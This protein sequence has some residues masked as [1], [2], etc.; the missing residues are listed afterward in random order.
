LLSNYVKG[1]IFLITLKKKG[2]DD[3]RALFT[4]LNDTDI[5]LKIN[6][7]VDERIK[8]LQE[9]DLLM[10]KLFKAQKM[11]RGQNFQDAISQLDILEEKYPGF[12]IVSELKA[13]AYY[14]NKD[15]EKSLSY[16]R[17]AFSLNPKNVDAYKMK[18]YLE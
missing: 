15:M 11:I 16:Y 5:D 6:M 4:K 9:H 8:K 1:S 14:L 13:I 12:S 18:V 17:K 7:Q 2:F 10:I 3:Y